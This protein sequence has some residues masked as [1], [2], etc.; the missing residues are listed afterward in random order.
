ME[1]RLGPYGLREDATYMQQYRADNPDVVRRYRT[2]AKA[3]TE[4]L[5]RLADRYP[6]EYKRLLEEV[7]REYGV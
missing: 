6:V 4:A 3:K 2:V 1:A 5:R 7:N